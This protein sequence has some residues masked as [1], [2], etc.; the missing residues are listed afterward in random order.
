[1]AHGFLTEVACDL[2]AHVA[3]A[4]AYVALFSGFIAARRDVYLVG[5]E[6]LSVRSFLVRCRVVLFGH[7]H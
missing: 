2:H 7:S 1:M 5:H 4:S 3:Q 6:G